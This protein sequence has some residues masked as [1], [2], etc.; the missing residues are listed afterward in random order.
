M[1]DPLS[2]GFVGISVVSSDDFNIFEEDLQSILLFPRPT[3]DLLIFNL[4]GLE[5]VS[6]LLGRIIEND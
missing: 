6:R 1:I 5:V 2:I 4:I 3:I